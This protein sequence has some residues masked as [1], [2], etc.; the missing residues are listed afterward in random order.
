ML[1]FAIIILLRLFSLGVKYQAFLQIL[2]GTSKLVHSKI[3]STTPLPY[4]GQRDS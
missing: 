3:I 4:A 1:F 2:N